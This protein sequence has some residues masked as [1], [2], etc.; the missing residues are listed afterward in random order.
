MI[1]MYLKITPGGGFR[2]VDWGGGSQGERHVCHMTILLA[3][4]E[5]RS[6]VNTVS[7]VQNI[8]NRIL[9]CS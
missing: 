4:S 2:G 8:P 3:L 7:D 1:D 6:V 9:S 5:A